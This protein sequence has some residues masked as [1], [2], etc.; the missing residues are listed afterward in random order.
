MLIIL[1]TFLIILTSR[2][3][4]KIVMTAI[5]LVMIVDITERMVMVDKKDN[6]VSC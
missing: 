2:I 3:A 5:F 4:Y 6:D 1:A